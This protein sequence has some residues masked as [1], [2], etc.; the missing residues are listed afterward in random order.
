MTFRYHG[1]WC[2]PGWSDGRYVPSTQGFAPAIDEFDETCRQHDFAL[3]GGRSDFKADTSFVSANIGRGPKRTLAAVLVAGRAI[4]DQLSTSNKTSDTMTQN[5]RGSGKNQKSQKANTAHQAQKQGPISKAG[6]KSH[7]T[8]API[9]I[10]TVVRSTPTKHTQIKNGAILSGND[11]IASVEG[12]GN[13]DFT[14]G[15]SAML[16]PA[17]FLSTFLGNMARSFEKY[18]W[19]RLRIHYVPRVATTT[20]GQVVLCSSHSVSLPCLQG[21]AGTFLQRAMA[22]GN[23]SLGPLWMENYIDIKC[24]NEFLMVDPTTTPD[25]DDAIAEELQVYVQSTV[26]GQVGYLY[27][28]YE[29]EFKDLTYQPHAVTIPVYTGPGLRA[30]L[31]DVAAVNA[32]NDDWNLSDIDGTLNVASTGNGTIFRAVFD[33]SSST[34]AAPATFSNQLVA[35]IS[36]R[37]TTSAFQTDTSNLPLSGGSTFYLVIAGTRLLVYTSL[38]AAINGNGT[39]QIFHRTATTSAGNYFFDCAIVRISATSLATVQ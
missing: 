8:G 31:T 39:G 35:G 26:V 5:L 11:F 19:K 1:N 18:R 22:Q 23:A 30:R 21:E 38:E 33:R 37:T 36:G 6:M 7:S 3:S 29:I 24:G 16:S 9:A 27:A 2:G 13:G 12:S 15:K 32:V 14:I 20:T 25:L 28:D 4:S 17:Y 10:G 34:A